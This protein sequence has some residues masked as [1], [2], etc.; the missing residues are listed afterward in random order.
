MSDLISREEVK[1]LTTKRNNIWNEITDAE[2]RGLDEILDSLPSIDAVPAK[3]GRWQ[4]IGGYGYK[5]R[6]SECIMCVERISKYCP[7][8]GARMDG[9]DNG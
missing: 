9:E 8:C 6:C 5:H 1:R 4:Y 2:G 3:H 7:H